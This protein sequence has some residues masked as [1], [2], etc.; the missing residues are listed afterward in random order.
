MAYR[1]GSL[2][3]GSCHKSGW[4][5][6]ENVESGLNNAGDSFFSGL[7]LMMLMSVLGGVSFI[8]FVIGVVA[9]FVM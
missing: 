3:A 1:G 9:K 4:Q 6:E 7:I 5:N 8:L 2:L